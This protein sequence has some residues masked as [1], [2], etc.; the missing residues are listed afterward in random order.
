MTEI[1]DL[2][3]Y[4]HLIDLA[5]EEDIGPGDITTEAVVSAE[6]A[7]RGTFVAHEKGVVSGLFMIEPLFRKLDAAAQVRVF[8]KDSDRIEPGQVLASVDCRARAV[9]AGERVALNFLQRLSGIASYARR[10]ADLV[11]GTNAKVLDT[12]KTIPGWRHLEKYAARCGGA[13]NHRVGLYDMVLIKENHQEISHR[14]LRQA[15]AAAREGVPAGVMV[16]VEVHDLADALDAV[17]GGADVIMLDNMGLDN[18]RRGVEIIREASKRLGRHVTIEFSGGITLDNLRDYAK[19][20]VDWISL[21]AIT[22]SAP[23]LDI[24]LD[25]EATD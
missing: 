16:E 9:L 11:E 8:V 17:E 18:R 12:R 20:G 7:A 5:L 22:H 1:P 13:K 19:F 24:S 15:I 2:A 4:D 14:S 6:Q 10:C 3:K 23:A 21:G 25:I